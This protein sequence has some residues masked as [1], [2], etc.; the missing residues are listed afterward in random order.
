MTATGTSGRHIEVNGVSLYVEEHGDGVPV[1]LIHG[2]TQNLRMWNAAV[3]L[4][5]THF[6][7]ITFDTRSHGLSTNPSDE[8]SYRLITDDTAALVE[9]LDLDRPF[10]GGYSDGGVVAVEFGVHYPHLT[11]GLI[12][13][14]AMTDY[15]SGAAQA[16]LRRIFHA[17]Q[18]GNIDFNELER[19]NPAYVARLRDRHTAD[20]EQWRR[21]SRQALTMWLEYPGFNEEQV[22][23]ITTQAIVIHAD[24]DKESPLEDALNLYRWLP[25]AELAVLPGCNHLRPQLEPAIFVAV[26]TDFIER[27]KDDT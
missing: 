16:N 8:L 13:G 25:N 22:T 4:L 17:D 3:P 5:A 1:V 6:R 24:H 7:V 21:V 14:G 12:V 15:Q 11:R 20:A 23:R 26:L 18:Q 9:A 27:H 10:V 19:E 2:G